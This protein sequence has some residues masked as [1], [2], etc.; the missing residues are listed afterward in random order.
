MTARVELQ[1]PAH[2]L[3]ARTP[4][5]LLAM[6]RRGLTEAATMCTDG[7]RYATAH[8]AALRAGAAVLAARATPA[9]GVR[10]ARPTSMWTLL[11]QVAPEL[12]AWCTYFA[13]RAST[14]AAAEAGI[15]RAVTAAEADAAIETAE[16]FIAICEIAAGCPTPPDDVDALLAELGDLGD[17]P[18]GA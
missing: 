3:P 14:R 1:V 6:A 13:E 8:L 16:Q 10:R 4:R 15:P 5:D 18:A 17:G 12:T 2:A 7:L 11:V 9:P